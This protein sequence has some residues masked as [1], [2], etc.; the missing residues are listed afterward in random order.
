M[1]PALA[2]LLRGDGE[3]LARRLLPVPV[4]LEAPGRLG[5]LDDAAEDATVHAAKRALHVALGDGG[6]PP[7]PRRTTR[8]TR[9]ASRG[10]GRANPPRVRRFARDGPGRVGADDPSGVARSRGRRRERRAETKPCSPPRERRHLALARPGVGWRPTEGAAA[11]SSSA[12]TFGG[13]NQNR[14]RSWRCLPA[15]VSDRAASQTSREPRPRAHHTSAARRHARPRH[16][17]SKDDDDST[18]PPA[19]VTGA[20]IP[21]DEIR[22]AAKARKV[23]SSRSPD[24][25]S[26]FPRLVT[27]AHPTG[28]RRAAGG[29]GGVQS[30]AARAPRI[31][32]TRSRCLTV[33]RR[34]SWSSGRRARPLARP[35]WASRWRSR[36][37]PPRTPELACRLSDLP[38]RT[39]L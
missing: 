36:S 4:A 17:R 29:A 39:R 20:V 15:V 24:D 32:V 11:E 23:R 6:G 18:M 3:G 30:R 26:P 19:V 5:H 2:R 35:S 1:P 12:P 10:C 21:A 8:C 14:N 13:E 34:V 25:G 7:I 37:S 22:T 16:S 33:P 31:H 27:C 28:A 9:V 38:T